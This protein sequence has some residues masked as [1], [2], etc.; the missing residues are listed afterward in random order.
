MSNTPNPRG[1][2]FAAHELLDIEDEDG[3][4]DDEGAPIHLCA[5]DVN[6]QKL[7]PIAVFGGNLLCAESERGSSGSG[8]EVG[9]RGRDND[10]CINV[11]LNWEKL[12]RG[13]R[14]LTSV[15]SSANV[16]RIAIDAEGRSAELHDEAQLPRDNRYFLRENTCGFADP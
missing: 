2:P 15:V 3:D 6:K 13:C 9:E 14:A 11:P 4:A 7:K 12:V 5:C 16:P 8:S 10:G 1:L